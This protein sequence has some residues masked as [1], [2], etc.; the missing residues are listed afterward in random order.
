MTALRMSTSEKV[1]YLVI[2]ASEYDHAIYHQQGY[3]VEGSSRALA[4]AQ[5]QIRQ[6]KNPDD[7][8]L[9]CNR[10]GEVIMRYVWHEGQVW[11]FTAGSLE[12]YCLD[13]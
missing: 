12:P 1:H 10:K 3:A 2:W 5:A 9:I 4:Q 11:E 6:F 7:M 13:T 8:L